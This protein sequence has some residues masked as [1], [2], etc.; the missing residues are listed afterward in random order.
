MDLEEEINFDEEQIPE[1][2]NNNL[3]VSRKRNRDEDDEE[4]ETIMGTLKG[5]L[6]K[7]QKI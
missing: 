1:L 6:Q 4:P 7:K 3:E 2:N 5:N